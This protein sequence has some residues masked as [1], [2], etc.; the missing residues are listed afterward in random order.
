MN[1]SAT[2]T[3]SLRILCALILACILVAGLWP[4]Q[5]PWNE[6]EWAEG[7]NGIRFGGRGVVYSFGPNALAESADTVSSA[8]EIWLQSGR[9]RQVGTI[10]EFYSPA[11]PTDFSLFQENSGLGF[12]LHNQKNLKGPHFY[13]RLGGVFSFL[14]PVFITI[15]SNSKMTS[16]YVDGVLAKTMPNFPLVFRNLLGQ[17]IAGGPPARQGWVGR[18]LGIAT[19]GRMLTP[20]EVALHYQSWTSKGRPEYPAST[21][22]VALYLFDE[23]SGSLIHNV[24]GTGA[25]LNIPERYANIHQSLLALSPF[26]RSD[27]SDILLNIAGFVPLGFFFRAYFSSRRPGALAAIVTILLGIAISLTMEVLQ[28]YLPTRTSDLRDVITNA[29]GTAMGVFLYQ[30]RPARTVLAKWCG[31]GASLR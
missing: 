16:V 29:L 22:N 9:T 5:R 10:I 26:R 20:A 28:S 24:L 14:E 31:A 3:R 25:D 27:W 30:T 8:L 7:G 11:D 13:D 17:V 4:F 15:T 18:L 19:Y 21:G 2:S 12:R 23:H 6:V 1:A